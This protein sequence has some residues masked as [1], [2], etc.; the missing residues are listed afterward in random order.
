MHV[1]FARDFE[2]GTFS[3]YSRIVAYTKYL[4]NVQNH[5]LL[6]SLSNA[7]L[8]TPG[9]SD[10]DGAA[11][12]DAHDGTSNTRIVVADDSTHGESAVAEV[13]SKVDDENSDGESSTLNSSDGFASASAA[14]DALVNGVRVLD[15]WLDR[16][17]PDQFHRYVR[18][19][20]F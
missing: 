17:S 15:A 8:C 1:C 3:L 13:D 6:N 9:S 18:G 11:Y 12:E 2:V 7:C 10:D 19:C 5:K 16:D 20:V 14:L 4:S